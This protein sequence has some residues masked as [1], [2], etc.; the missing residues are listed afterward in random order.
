MLVRGD[1]EEQVE[2]EVKSTFCSQ[3]TGSDVFFDFES[4]SNIEEC[5]KQALEVL[6]SFNDHP[7]KQVDEKLLF[8]KNT[9]IST[10]NHFFSYD[11]VYIDY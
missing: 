5:C 9:K 8:A 11:L 10:G 6:S 1:T 7:T 3:S 2:Q 4:S